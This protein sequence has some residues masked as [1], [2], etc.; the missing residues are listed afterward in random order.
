[1]YA[2]SIGG[3]LPAPE[4]GYL[5]VGRPWG[6]FAHI[7]EGCARLRTPN[8]YTH[9][10]PIS[11]SPRHPRPPGGGGEGIFV[12]PSRVGKGLP[13]LGFTQAAHV[14]VYSHVKMTFSNRSPK[15]GSDGAFS[16]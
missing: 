12:V 16:D 11:L 3:Q 6:T 9:S 2:V 1:M 7:T 10:L 4:L 8:T 13:G 5:G 14:I 15:Q